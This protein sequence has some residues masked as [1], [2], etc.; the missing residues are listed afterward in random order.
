VRFEAVGT[1]LRAY[2]DGVLVITATRDAVSRA[3]AVGMQYHEVPE[4]T[5]SDLARYLSLSWDSM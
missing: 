4:D 1:E 3:G 5:R 2:V